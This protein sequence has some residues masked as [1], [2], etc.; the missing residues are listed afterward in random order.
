MASA[1]WDGRDFGDP[2]VIRM[3]L[4]GHLRRLRETRGVSAEEAG[5]EIRWPASEIHRMEAGRTQFRA[6]EVADMLDLY[7]VDDDHERERLL[8]LAQESRT[9]N[10]WRRYND[11]L[12]NWFL[13]YLGL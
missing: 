13:S 3:L 5:W 12:A 4:G 7:G 8:A 6:H 10:W 1:T 11:R 9:W 2:T